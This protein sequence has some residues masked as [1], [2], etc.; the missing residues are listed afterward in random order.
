MSRL[1]RPMKIAYNWL[2]PE[3]P[4]TISNGVLLY[5]PNVIRAAAI[6]FCIVGIV[7]SVPYSLEHLDDT[8]LVVTRLF[9]VGLA[10]LATALVA[11]LVERYY[12]ACVLVCVLLGI[13]VTLATPTFMVGPNINPHAMLALIY[14][15]GAGFC[16]GRRGVVIALGWLI[17]NYSLL[18]VTANWDVWPHPTVI[19]V[20]AVQY[21]NVSAMFFMLLILVPLLLGYLALVERSIKEL[22][23]SHADQQQL[24][25]RLI[26]TRE[27][28]RKHLAHVLHEGPVQNLGALR[29]AIMNQQSSAEMIP[30]VDSTISELRALSTS[31][32]PAILDLYGLPAALDQLAA[33]RGG[34]IQ[35]QVDSQRL[36]YLDPYVGI[37][38]FRIAQEALT[39]IHKHSNAQHAWVL[40]EQIENN[41]ILEIRDDGQGFDVKPAQRSTVQAGH[42]GLATMHELAMSIG[43]DLNIMSIPG[44]G[45]LI[46][47]SAPYSASTQGQDSRSHTDIS[48]TSEREGNRSLV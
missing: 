12:K 15:L 25:Q 4:A 2:R 17:L 3:D 34:A 7:F 14:V 46:K 18:V 22:Q 9:V 13:T 45:T 31:L 5:A 8:R 26:A 11:V 33:Q 47:I 36:G 21:E 24:L 37:V 19:S 28:E 35:V 38:L 23:K 48:M 43:G 30:L 1:A 6:I 10:C 40:L 32:H 16:L 27:S 42:L 39:N 20:G 41:V 29:L 44:Q